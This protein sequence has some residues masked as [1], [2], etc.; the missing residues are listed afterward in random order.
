MNLDLI[1]AILSELLYIN[2]YSAL[3]VVNSDELDY[4]FRREPGEKD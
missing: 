2:L 1:V 3:K 4:K